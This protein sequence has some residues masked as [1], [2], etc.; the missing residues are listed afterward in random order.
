MNEEQ[1]LEKHMKLV[2]KIA[3]KYPKHCKL[4]M[5]DRVQEGS[6]GLLRAIREYDE[7][8]KIPFGAFAGQ[9]IQWAISNAMRNANPVKLSTNVTQLIVY[10]KTH[11]LQDLTVDELVERT[12]ESRV[13]AEQ[14]IS[15]L[16]TDF[17]SLDYQMEGKDGDADSFYNLK[18]Y[19]QD[20]ETGV[21]LHRCFEHLPERTVMFFRLYEQGYTQ[22]EIGKMYGTVSQNVNHH[23]KQAHKKLK[24]LRAELIE[25]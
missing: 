25:L 7:S 17:R 19:E 10:I 13:V 5:E 24:A 9:H 12:K 22:K 4:P 20:F 2:Y 21:L 3:G 8:K 23:M 18:G 16:K 1:M 6:I 15:F 14:A 11:E